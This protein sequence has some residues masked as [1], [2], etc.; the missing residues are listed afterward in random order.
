LIFLTDYSEILQQ[1]RNINPIQYGKTRNYV[2]GAVTKLSPYI[3]RG[4]ISTKQ[5]LKTVLEKGHKRHEIEIF[6]K[7]LAWREYF[8]RVWMAKDNEIDLDLKNP[9]QETNNQGI[10]SAIIAHQTGIEAIDKAIHELYTEG[11]VHNHL[12]MYIASVCC[13][14]SKS[15]WHTPAQWMYYHLLD[16]DWASNALS[17]Q[18]VAGSFSSKK[19]Y[20]NQDN[21]NQFCHTQQKGT[22][23]DCSYE[24]LSQMDVPSTLKETITPKLITNLPEVGSIE[25]DDEKPVCVYNF[26]NLDSGWMQDIEA[27]RILLLEPSFFKKYPSGDNAIQ[28]VLDVSKNI[29]NIQIVVADFEEVFNNVPDHKIH[30]KEHPSN[31]HY[32]GTVHE[33]DWIFPEV[34]GYYPSFSSYWKKCERHLKQLFI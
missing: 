7:E 11:Y 8:Q 4:V 12:R 16:A 6:V 1:V 17:W 32:K 20:A 13:N 33:R 19:Y 15:H 30:F 25:L 3:S 24:K 29:K 5:I 28:F 26:Y 27:N 18:W 2:D 34:E 22:F 31:K 21:V 14:V 9:Q 23:L 10:P